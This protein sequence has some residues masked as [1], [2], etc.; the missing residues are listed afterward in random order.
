MAWQFLVPLALG[1]AQ[2]AANADKERRDRMVAGVQQAYSPWTGMQARTPESGNPV[3]NLIG[4]AATGMQLSQASEA[5]QNQKELQD[6]LKQRIQ[7]QVDYNRSAANPYQM[8]AQM[9]PASR[10][11]SIWSQV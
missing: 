5:A 3:G 7:S 10:G 9:L 1:A 6:L 4:A 2:N 11:G 8:K